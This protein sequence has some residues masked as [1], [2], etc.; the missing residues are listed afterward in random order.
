MPTEDLTSDLN[1][2]ADFNSVKQ[3]NKNNK[4]MDRSSM[5][6]DLNGDSHNN[7]NN[8]NINTEDDIKTPDFEVD[9]AFQVNSQLYF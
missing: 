6:I 3:R 8:N 1:S 5:Q 7:N 4:K 9:Y 2:E